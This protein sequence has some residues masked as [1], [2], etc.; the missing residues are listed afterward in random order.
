MKHK[1]FTTFIFCL[2]GVLFSQLKSQSTIIDVIRWDNSE[3]KVELSALNK[4]TFTTDHLVFNYLNGVVENLPKSEIRK[5]VFGTSTAVNP[6]VS[7]SAIQVYPNPTYEFIRIKNI[8]DARCRVVV[9][10]ITGS[11]VLNI[12]LNSPTQQIDVSALP[13]GL[14][15]LKANNQVAKFTKQ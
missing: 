6:L 5:L 2:F 8:P 15:Y 3:K 14:Y 10:S 1:L 7:Q 11:Q 9:Y 13:R 4:L 12:Q